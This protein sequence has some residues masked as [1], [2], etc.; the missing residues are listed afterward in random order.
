V[1]P[2]ALLQECPLA[3]EPNR[4]ADRVGHCQW[5]TPPEHPEGYNLIVT[6]YTA[7]YGHYLTMPVGYAKA[8]EAALTPVFDQIWIGDAKVADVLPAAVEEANRIMKE[9]QAR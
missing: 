5:C 6:E 1:V 9:E 7:K 8:N 4:A 3:A 2:G